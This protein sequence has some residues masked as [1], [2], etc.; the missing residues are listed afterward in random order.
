M[1]VTRRYFTGF[2]CSAMP[3]LISRELP[4]VS[5]YDENTS[6]TK[7]IIPDDAKSS[8]ITEVP[9]VGNF[10]LFCV[11]ES[12]DVQTYYYKNYSF[13]PIEV[14]FD[15]TGDSF[16][17]VPEGNFA[18][19]QDKNT[20]IISLPVKEKDSQGSEI[21]AFTIKGG[22]ECKA[23]YK[24]GSIDCKHDP[25]ATYLIPFPEGRRYYVHQ[26]N[27]GPYTHLGDAKFA[28]D[29]R[30]YD[31]V[32]ENH[33][34]AMRDGIVV[35]IKEDST[36]YGRTEYH[37]D[38]ANKVFILH[39]DGSRSH[40]GHLIKNSVSASGIKLGDYVKA[41]QI[42]GRYGRTGYLTYPHVHVSVNVLKGF[43]ETER[44]DISGGFKGKNGKLIRL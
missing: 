21:K 11:Q 22:Y 4:L 44:I 19:I 12:E 37:K 40:Y 24:F 17:I 36:E 8:G 25:N 16:E 30:T 23:F 1:I 31:D 29:F 26:G 2:L 35:L 9:Y 34:C 15:L 42:V 28:F 13:M 33:V 14:K 3:Y 20:L 41:G 6:K 5:A 7:S 18:R 32:N 38:K 39:D 43:G 10:E 27:N